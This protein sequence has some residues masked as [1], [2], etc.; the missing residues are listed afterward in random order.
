MLGVV[1][2]LSIKG[3]FMSY[4]LNEVYDQQDIYEI[5]DLLSKNFGKPVII[6]NADFQL[7]S[8]SSLYIEDFDEA[9]QHTILSKK[10]PEIILKRFIQE[11]I[12]K[13]LKRTSDPFRIEPIEDIGLN[14]RVVVTSRYKSQIMGYIWIQEVDKRLTES[15]LQVLKQMASHIGKVI[16]LMNQTKQVK[17]KEVDLFYSNLI[18]G[19]F[20]DVRRIRKE[21]E[22]IH[23]QLPQSFVV[24]VFKAFDFDDPKLWKEFENRVRIHLKDTKKFSY[25]LNEPSEMITVIGDSTLASVSQLAADIVDNVL[26]SSNRQGLI[27]ITVGIGN[28]YDHHT[29]FQKSYLEALEVIQITEFMGSSTRVPVEFR[30]L[31]VYRYLE[32]LSERNKKRGYVNSDLEILIKKDKEN[33]SELVKTLKAYL[34]H[35]GKLKQTAEALFIHPN[36]LNYRMKQISDLISIDFNNFNLMCQLYMDLILIDDMRKY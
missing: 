27:Q 5:T 34:N 17:K 26:S 16:Y 10:H 13:K 35:N 9:N 30:K 8:Y 4:D 24:I 18:H 14:Q 2:F 29:L 28:A 19:I 12:V 21:A 36:T 1:G 6:E 32:T 22:S 23:V 20:D 31:G 25:L 15:E 33:Q 7:I 11:G 3:E